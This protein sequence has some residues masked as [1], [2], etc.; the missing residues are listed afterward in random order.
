MYFSS[1]KASKAS[2]QEAHVV[3]QSAGILLAHVEA[4]SLTWIYKSTNVPLKQPLLDATE[5]ATFGLFFMFV[6]AGAGPKSDEDI[7]EIYCRTSAGEMKEGPPRLLILRSAAKRLGSW[8][9]RR[10]PHLC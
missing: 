10:E 7:V 9:S 8:C 5:A 4:F 2:Q 6:C 3:H 1:S